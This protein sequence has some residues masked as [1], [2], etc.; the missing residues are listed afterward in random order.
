M[1]LSLA[2]PKGGDVTIRVY[3]SSGREVA[4][5]LLS[6]LKAGVQQDQWDVRDRTRRPLASGGYYV[7][8][9]APSGERFTRWLDLK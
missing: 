1:N 9:D 3:D 4:Q 2:L 7:R 6:G 5:K 8:V